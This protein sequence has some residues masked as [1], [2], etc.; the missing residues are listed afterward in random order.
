[1]YS[2][3]QPVWA[4]ELVQLSGLQ[5]HHFLNVEQ[6]II[7]AFEAAIPTESMMASSQLT[8]DVN[9]LQTSSHASRA[10]N[11]NERSDVFEKEELERLQEKNK[12]LSAQK[13]RES[14][15]QSMSSQSPQ[16]PP[17]PDQSVSKFRTDQKPS[18]KRQSAHLR[19][20]TTEFQT[21]EALRDG[22]NIPLRG[23]DPL[24]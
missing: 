15:H 14:T 6:K 8:E 23:R 1:M 13:P 5:H 3:V 2:K 16:K 24:V 21:H 10:G 20:P 19:A 22:V 7:E 11:R 12:V 18:E 4:A 9:P 17:N